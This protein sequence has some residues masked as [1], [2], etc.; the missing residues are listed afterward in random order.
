MSEQAM[1]VP[2][3]ETL[4]IGRVQRGRGL[5]GDQ[6]RRQPDQRSRRGDALLLA[7]AQDGGLPIQ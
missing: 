1:Q 7:D 3:T 2:A 5:I 4:A 6:Q